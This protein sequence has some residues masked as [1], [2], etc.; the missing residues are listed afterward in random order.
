MASLLIWLWFIKS[1]FSIKNVKLFFKKIKMKKNNKDR[2]PENN[3]TMK[4]KPEISKKK[5]KQVEENL[6]FPEEYEEQRSM[7]IRMRPQPLVK[8]K[9]DK[10]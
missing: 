10:D 2:L 9:K 7:D 1:L 8:T 3:E 6:M 5:L 4:Q